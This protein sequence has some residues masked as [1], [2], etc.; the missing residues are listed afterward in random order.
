MM[1][2][3]LL[4][5]RKMHGSLSEQNGI[6]NSHTAILREIVDSQKEIAATLRRIEDKIGS[7]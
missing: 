5:A 4:V 3:T 7:K 2:A 6:L 1:L